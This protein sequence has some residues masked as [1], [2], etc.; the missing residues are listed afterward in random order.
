MLHVKRK[1]PIQKSNFLKVRDSSHFTGRSM[2]AACRFCYL[3]K[4]VPQEIPMVMHNGLPF[5]HKTTGK[6]IQK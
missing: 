6:L 1:T 3:I 5:Y 4:P 2:Y